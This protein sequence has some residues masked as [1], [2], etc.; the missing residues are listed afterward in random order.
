MH[1]LAALS[2]CSPAGKKRR[3]C[4]R[5]EYRIWQRASTQRRREVM[6]C[7]RSLRAHS[8]WTIYWLRIGRRCKQNK[9]VRVSTW[10][11]PSD[12]PELMV[13]ALADK[14]HKIEPTGIFHAPRRK[15]N[16]GEKST[17]QKLLSA[18]ILSL[19]RS[20][21][22]TGLWCLKLTLVHLLWCLLCTHG[23]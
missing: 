22:N 8:G 4:T 9:T 15:T 11:T 1:L 16:T 10:R 2:L 14:Y 7:S 13:L 18:N 19:S 5:G 12:A 6:L 17:P 20:A 3:R 23:H 21:A